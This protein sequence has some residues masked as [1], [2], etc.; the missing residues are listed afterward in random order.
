MT[1]DFNK[2]MLM[3][4]KTCE[5]QPLDYV[6][7]AKNFTMLYPFTTENIAG[8]IDLFDLQNKSL[9]TVGSSLDQAFNAI[10]ANCRDITV[11]DLNPQTKFY[12]FLK[13][14]A[15]L[16]LNRQEFLEYLRF[17]DYPS[18]FKDNRKAFDKETF[19]KLKKT[20]RLLDYESYLYWDELFENYGPIKVRT[21]LFSL[22]EDR[23]NTIVGCN[24]YLQTEENYE[25]LRSKIK[26]YTPNFITANIYDAKI[27]RK[28]DSIWLSNIFYHLQAGESEK[29]GFLTKKMV[30]ALKEN[31][32]LLITYLYDTVEETAYQEGWRD[33]YNL[34]EVYQVLKDYSPALENFPGVSSLRF[35][36]KEFKD[37]VL[38]Y[39]K[40]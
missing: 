21:S 17:K 1:D 12:Y 7:L 33:I 10:E 2:I 26:K 37:S 25:S 36:N 24:K 29:I 28:Y 5:D 11:L 27:N 6:A 16:E 20:L 8:Y 38:V 23:T 4:I 30:D 3:A 15:L 13:T 35:S 32:K 18:V 39:Q 31:G 34:E 9:L 40:K 14:A 22:D 19:N